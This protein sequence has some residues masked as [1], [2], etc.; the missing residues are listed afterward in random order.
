MALDLSALNL[1]VEAAPTT[2]V[3]VL[4]TSV[5]TDFTFTGVPE[6]YRVRNLG[7][8]G[9]VLTKN[10]TQPF[11]ASVSGTANWE[12]LVWTDA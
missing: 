10:F 7:G 2:N 12:D 3:Y 9:Y 8:N 1:P 5:K 6:G 4:I 11:S